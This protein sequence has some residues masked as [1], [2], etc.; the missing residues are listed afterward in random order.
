[1]YA[2]VKASCSR[3]TRPC[4]DGLLLESSKIGENR[5]KSKKTPMFQIQAG[6]FFCQQLI[7]SCCYSTIPRISKRPGSKHT[8][9]MKSSVKVGTSDVV[10]PATVRWTSLHYRAAG[11][12]GQYHCSYRRQLSQGLRLDITRNSLLLD[13]GG[14]EYSNAYA[15]CFMIETYSLS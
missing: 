8:D 1:M 6:H 11:G 5:Q 7:N 14:E 9:L 10:G 4:S 12:D 3:E 2:N 13:T 15:K